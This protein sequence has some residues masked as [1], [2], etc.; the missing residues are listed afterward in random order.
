MISQ[1]ADGYV[2][3]RLD[4]SLCRFIDHC[5]KTKKKKKKK[6]TEYLLETNAENVAIVNVE[7]MNNRG[8]YICLATFY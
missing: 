1:T 7:K 3:M 2:T 8:I 5:K 4:I 6:W